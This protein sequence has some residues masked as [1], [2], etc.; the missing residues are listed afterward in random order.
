[1]WN[2]KYSNIIITFTLE[3]NVEDGSSISADLDSGGEIQDHC[4]GSEL[5]GAQA[6]PGEFNHSV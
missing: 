6:I 3:N 2:L 4:L 1:L 5:Q